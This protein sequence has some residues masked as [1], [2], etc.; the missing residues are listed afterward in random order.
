MLFSQ[1]AC[2]LLRFG[3]VCLFCFPFSVSHFL[4]FW[5]TVVLCACRFVHAQAQRV[6]RRRIRGIRRRPPSPLLPR[7]TVAVP[8]RCSNRNTSWLAG[9]QRERRLR[10]MRRLDGAR[11]HHDASPFSCYVDMIYRDLLFITHNTCKQKLEK[12][13][14][15]SGQHTHFGIMHSA[16]V[17]CQ[18]G[19]FY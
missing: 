9:P 2:L 11:A 8:L 14:T 19:N 4:T 1:F 12:E 3:S 5:F 10:R 16:P 17:R 6:A 7:G 13:Q 18:I 15:H